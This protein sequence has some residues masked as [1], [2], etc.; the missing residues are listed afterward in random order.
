[1]RPAYWL[2]PI[3]I[4]GFG[5]HTTAKKPVV[6]G[7]STP[8]AAPPTPSQ[9]PELPDAKI[10]PFEP[11]YKTLP[12]LD[13][14][15]AATIDRKPPKGIED[16]TVESV[17]GQRSTTARLLDLENELMNPAASSDVVREARKLL[18]MEARNKSVGEALGTFYQ[19]ADADGR[20]DLLRQSLQ[21]LSDLRTVAEKAKAGGARVPVEPEDLDQQKG[22]TLGV[23][24]QAELGA[25]LLEIDLLRRLG[26]PGNG[27][28]RLRPTGKFELEWPAPLPAD[29][30][31]EALE[32]RGD[33]L[34]LRLIYTR[35]DAQTLPTIRDYI[36][37]ANPANAVIA[38]AVPPIP[39]VKHVVQK[40]IAAAEAQAAMNTASEVEIRKQQLFTMIE[41]KE[42]ITADE[43]RAALLAM[44]EQYRQV[45]LARGRAE[46]SITKL[47]ELKR[48]TKGPFLEVPA[49]I[50]V[51]RARAEVLAAVMGWHQARVK[52]A[53]AQGKY[54]GK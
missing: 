8:V 36:R 22:Q 26:L 30:I 5:C 23:L 20:S 21:K 28:E 1:M 7:S 50:E 6:V 2:L 25:N 27:K 10:T 37:G 12:L 15:T 46:Q 44:E 31:K 16:S 18:A 14:R 51:L 43:V 17:V 53:V 34:A 47:A 32:N 13:T 38:A 11:D 54:S 40:R 39:L 52:L 24:G 29:A 45:G 41:E 49:E 42:R 33:L 35:L 9:P 4:A 19:L 48:Q 3:A